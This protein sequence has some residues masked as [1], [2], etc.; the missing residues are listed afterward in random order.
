MATTYSGTGNIS[1]SDGYSLTC[2]VVI[3]N[4]TTTGYDVELQFT[5]PVFGG[6]ASPYGSMFIKGSEISYT[7]S[8]VSYSTSPNFPSFG[9]NYTSKANVESNSYNANGFTLSGSASYICTS[10]SNATISISIPVHAGNY[11][12]TI[13]GT[14]DIQI[15]NV[16]I[17]ATESEK[18][19]IF[20][21]PN[22]GSGGPTSPTYIEE[23]G[24]TYISEETPEKISEVARITYDFDTNYSGGE[25]SSSTLIRQETYGFKYWSE[26]ADDSTGYAC[27]SG[28]WTWV[29]SGLGKNI[30]LYA[31]YYY[32][33]DEFVGLTIP[34]PV[35]DGYT[36]LGWYTNPT[37]GEMV[38][39]DS[40][41]S[42]GTQTLYAHWRSNAKVRL[43]D[44]DGNIEWKDCNI[45]IK[46]SDGTWKECTFNK[47]E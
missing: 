10:D 41:Y 40:I 47:I 37:G 22:G 13:L 3:S 45:T 21:N 30:T 36:F 39:Y 46:S 6:S 26:S 43:T 23:E 11:N 7:D 9:D 16:P 34:T 44:A 14:I 31:I 4:I 8:G 15:S 27:S 25:I 12:G 24:P 38:D 32:I 29:F 1:T 28:E 42:C 35:R 20:Y 5:Q 17:P 2:K 19:Y 18:Y 33:A